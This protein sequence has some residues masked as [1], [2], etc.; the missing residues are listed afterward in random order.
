[1]RVPLCH[2]CSSHVTADPEPGSIEAELGAKLI[3][4]CTEDDRIHDADTAKEFCP[5]IKK[6]EAS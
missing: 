1:M 2:K 4:G 5:A 3:V 6:A